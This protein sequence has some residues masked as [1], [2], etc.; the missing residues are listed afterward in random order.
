MNDGMFI[1]SIRFISHIHLGESPEKTF[2]KRKGHLK[3]DL[4]G[5]WMNQSDFF[6]ASGATW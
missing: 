5:D 3:K 2:G 4:E 6:P 1:K